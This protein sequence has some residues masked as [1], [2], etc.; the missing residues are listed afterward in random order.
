MSRGS[1]AGFDR[2]ITIFSPEGRLYQ[3]EYAFKAINQAGLTSIALK[4]TDTAVCVTQK[5]IPD[6]LIEANTI[7]H[8]FKLTESAGCVMTGMIADSKSQVQRARYEAANFKYK[9]GV[10]MPVDTLCRRI[11]DISQVYTQNAEMRPLGCSMIIIAYD[12]QVGPCVF[13]TDPA[14]YFCGF[15]AVSV[16]AKQTEANSYLE[17]KLKKKQ[18]LSHD[19]AIQLAIGCLSSVLSV[20]MKPS[21]I[22]VGVVSKDNPKFRKLSETEVDRHLTA[23]AEKD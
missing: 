4:G 20:D 11:A 22:E 10:E 9:Y 19:E 13:K 17:K 14:G 3:V 23:I 12:D 21:E 2:H 16:G 1:S 7:T 5:K 6:K 15:R 8:L 18:D